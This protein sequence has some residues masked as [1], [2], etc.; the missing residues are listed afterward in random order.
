V[1]NT[2][3]DA[4]IAPHAEN[5][6]L[7]LTLDDG[8]KVSYRNF[9]ARVGQLAHVL[10]GAGVK[11]GDRVVVQA[12]KVMDTIAL[13]GAAVQAGAVYLPL[14]TAY[15]QSELVYFI[16]DAT[17]SLVVCDAKKRGRRIRDLRR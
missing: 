15:T 5:D 1:T 9:V 2:L 10:A 6:A 8:T 13:Y 11:P 14:N 17:P 4:L 16:A 3:Y 7:F 12:P